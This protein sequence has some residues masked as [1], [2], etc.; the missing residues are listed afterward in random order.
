M[1][2]DRRFTS[3]Q[4]V[5]VL[6]ALLLAVGAMAANA[7]GAELRLVYGCP[8]AWEV[9]QSWS[10]QTPM[11]WR[12]LALNRQGGLD[13]LLTLDPGEQPFGRMNFYPEIGLFVVNEG[14][15]VPSGV[16]IVATNTPSV[17]SKTEFSTD[18]QVFKERVLTTD[19]GGMALRLEPAGIARS[20][21][22]KLSIE[23]IRGA[24]DQAKYLSGPV[25]LHLAGPGS[26]YCGLGGDVIDVV[27]EATGQL[28]CVDT[29]LPLALP[30]LPSG[31]FFSDA[32]RG[33]IMIGMDEHY[34][35]LVVT[36]FKNAMVDRELLVYNRDSGKWTSLMLPGG[37]T[38]PRRI[39]NRLAG[40][41]QEVSPETDVAIRKALPAIKRE[42]AVIIDP[43]NAT[44]V[45]VRL[46]KDNE[47]LWLDG[48]TLIYRL[49]TSLYSGRIDGDQ[50]VDRQL[51]LEDARIMNV[52][53]AYQSE[54]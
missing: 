25:T 34:F 22:P 27:R 30:V 13:E 28:R 12:V 47:I 9:G 31:V 52:H 6:L 1:L 46:G 51:L 45:T 36:P 37:R 8:Q 5:T 15:A 42:E 21:Q 43:V 20:E 17:L 48:D 49:G 23:V 26:A 18:F 35:A 53:W 3:K 4:A 24:Q 54:G 16:T 7:T 32:S 38:L 14:E 2:R 44:L 39:N 41:V 19:D 11:P 10:D 29:T 50:I 33:W 40:V